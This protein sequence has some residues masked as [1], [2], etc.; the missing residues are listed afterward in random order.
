MFLSGFGVRLY[1]IQI[2][3]LA[4]HEVSTL[5]RVVPSLVVEAI[6][7]TVHGVMPDICSLSRFHR[8]SV[9]RL[10][11]EDLRTWMANLNFRFQNLKLQALLQ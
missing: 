5:K 7:C 9:V 4:K 1:G 3:C 11:T 8:S 2:Y 10:R 6:F